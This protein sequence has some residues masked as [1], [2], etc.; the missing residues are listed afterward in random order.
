MR[1]RSLARDRNHFKQIYNTEINFW[2]CGMMKGLNIL[3][4]CLEID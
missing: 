2:V 1:S 3:K 4:I